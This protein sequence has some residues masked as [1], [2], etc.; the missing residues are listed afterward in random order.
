[1]VIA[2]SDAV[3][4]KVTE[5]V[6]LYHAYF[7]LTFRCQEKKWKMQSYEVNNVHQRIFVQVN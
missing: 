4:A 1:K 3:A 7:K 2:E 5:S 6:I